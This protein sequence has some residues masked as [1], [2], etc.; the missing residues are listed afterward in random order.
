MESNFQPLNTEYSAPGQI[1]QASLTSPEAQVMNSPAVIGLLNGIFSLIDI[2]MSSCFGGLGD[3]TTVIC[4]D[5]DK[6]KDPLEHSHG[7]ITYSPTSFDVTEIIDELA[8]LLTAGRLNKQSR[9][10]IT[11]AYTKK[12]E[13][14]D[15][16][17]ALRLAQKLIV[18]SPEFQSTAFF[19]GN[20][21]MRPDPIVPDP[22][23]HEYKA[24]VFLN[25]SKYD[26]VIMNDR[27]IHINQYPRVFVSNAHYC[28]RICFFKHINENRW[29]NGWI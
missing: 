10:L 15:E 23:G 22:T 17:Q 25:L 2:G 27:L 9:A 5:L 29:W 19:Y 6:D 1:S 24:I 13:D 14:E 8:L 20:S 26:I 12:A 7:I 4:N 3:T 18:S 11:S 28:V 21:Q 16:V